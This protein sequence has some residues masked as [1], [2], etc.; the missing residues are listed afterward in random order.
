MFEPEIRSL[1]AIEN[2][3]RMELPLSRTETRLLAEA[4]SKANA[5][6]R[7]LES[8]LHER[9]EQH[10]EVCARLTGQL[11][12]MRL[13]LEEAREEARSE[14]EQREAQRM[15]YVDCEE[16]CGSLITQVREHE[17]TIATLAPYRERW[18]DLVDALGFDVEQVPRGCSEQDGATFVHTSAI[19]RS[20]SLAMRAPVD[21][22]SVEVRLRTMQ[23]AIEILRGRVGNLAGRLARLEP[24]EELHG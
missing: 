9:R 15:T 3:A 5:R 23:D 10:H 4:L 24:D 21:P 19:A 17:A 16:Q 1:D 14:R 22:Q 6:G 11:A 8:A 18:R 12:A 20:K 2:A 13:Q 7:H